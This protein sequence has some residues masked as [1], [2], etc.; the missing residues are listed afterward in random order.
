MRKIKKPKIGDKIYV[1]SSFYI[2]HGSDDF[3]GGLCTI[4]GIEYSKTLPED[5]CNYCMVRIKERPSMVRIKERPS[6]AYNYLYL[7]EEQEELKEQFGDQVGYPDTD[8][9][10]PWLEKGDIV[11][12]GEIYDGDPMW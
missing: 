4:D 1:H 3:V 10:T 9:D 5:H 7:L 11:G 6:T 8:I 12:D 2:S